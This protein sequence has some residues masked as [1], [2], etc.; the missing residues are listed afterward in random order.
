MGLRGP[1]C[2][3]KKFIDGHIRRRGGPGIHP[4][5]WDSQMRGRII[6]PSSGPSLWKASENKGFGGSHAEGRPHQ[7]GA[8]H[9]PSV[10]T[11]QFFFYNLEIF[12]SKKKEKKKGQFFFPELF[13]FKTGEYNGDPKNNLAESE[14]GGCI[15]GPPLLRMCPSI[16][17][18]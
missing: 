7:S 11:L 10:V 2:T 1:R 3:H 13:F 17:F 14:P 16:N 5:R 18:L 15:P 6:T 12:F 9:P 8:G 4:P